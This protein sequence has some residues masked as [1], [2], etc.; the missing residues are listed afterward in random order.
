MAHYKNLGSYVSESTLLRAGFPNLEGSY[1]TQFDIN[2]KRGVLYNGCFLNYF[3]EKLELGSLEY[4]FVNLVV[5]GVK[6]KSNKKVMRDV[7]E[8]DYKV[9]YYF[10][11]YHRKSNDIRDSLEIKE[12]I[13]NSKAIVKR[14][15]RISLKN[16]EERMKQEL[17]KLK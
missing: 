9:D 11:V 15:N 12:L 6:R 16:L 5:I 8:G 17:E 4:D 1:S 14:K 3:N 7:K 10:G 2:G 13:K